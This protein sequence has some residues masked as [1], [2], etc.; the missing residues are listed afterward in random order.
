MFVR[1]DPHKVSLLLQ[2]N[3]E[4]DIDDDEEDFELDDD[5]HDGDEKMGWYW[6]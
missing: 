6:V 5:K 1:L 4:D 3:N 2:P